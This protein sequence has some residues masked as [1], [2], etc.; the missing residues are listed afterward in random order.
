MIIPII[1]DRHINGG[2]NVMPHGSNEVK[3]VIN[4]KVYDFPK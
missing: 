1:M 3:R 2:M 4:N